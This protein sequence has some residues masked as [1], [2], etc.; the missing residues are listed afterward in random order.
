MAIALQD[1]SDGI[2]C[3]AKMG[4]WQR[5]QRGDVDGGGG[6]GYGAGSDWELMIHQQW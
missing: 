2:G 5:Q 4:R 1:T 6:D 3:K